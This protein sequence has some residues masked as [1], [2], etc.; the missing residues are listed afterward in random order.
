M[1]LSPGTKMPFMDIE[2]AYQNIKHKTPV[3][4]VH[5]GNHALGIP[6]RTGAEDYMRRLLSDSATKI[7][8]WYRH[9]LAVRKR[10]SAM[11][12]NTSALKRLLE[13]KRQEHEVLMQEEE[14]REFQR[15]ENE[16]LAQES[17]RHQREQKAKEQRSSAIE[18]SIFF[19]CLSKNNNYFFCIL[20]RS[21]A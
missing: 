9:R 3:N 7:Q 5:G 2:N 10:Q 15:L 12:T 21:N 16:I 17:R 20:N 6:P 18:V 13:Q 4:Q 1:A 14:Q 8:R 11:L 19:H